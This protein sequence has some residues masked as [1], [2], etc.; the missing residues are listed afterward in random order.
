M[1]SGRTAE[2]IS[3]DLDQRAAHA[4][5]TPDA[6]DADWLLSIFAPPASD[7]PQPPTSLSQIREPFSFFPSAW[8]FAHTALTNLS[9][10]TP[11]AQWSADAEEQTLSI[12]PPDDLKY[13]L[14]Q[15]P[16]EVQAASYTLCANKHRVEQEIEA[17]RQR[18]SSASSGD[19][20]DAS[21]WP[22]LHYLWSQH[23]IL[24]WLGDRVL[25]AF[26][27]HRAPV[28]QSHLLA[29]DEHAWIL[30]SLIP[31]RK[32]QPMLAEWRVACRRGSGPCTLEDF[33]SF[34]QRA[35]LKSGSLPNPGQVN[36]APLQ[37]GVPAAV[38]AMRRYM[39]AR[40]TE[41]ASQ[42]D[43]RLHQ[44]LADLERLQDRQLS[45]LNQRYAQ[46][47]PNFRQ[48]R[49]DERSRSIRRVF[50]DYREWVRETMTT[51]PQPFIQLLAAVCR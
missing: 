46:L 31:N 1:A 36:L 16:R 41:F 14:R 26:G 20:S 32:A 42:M 33:H 9:K 43:A 4:D 25:T 48:K 51:E 7:Q 38:D 22:E 28:I 19:E 27:R 23:P 47:D 2:E 11:I 40:Q 12:T 5:S 24:E 6:T 45:D 17:A 37:A 21:T 18:Q 30:L 13:R 49:V 3:A 39:L 15:L 29:E 34:A 44:T 35:G 10:P 8:S 50:D